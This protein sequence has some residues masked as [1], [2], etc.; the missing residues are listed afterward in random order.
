MYGLQCLSLCNQV[1]NK[2]V[3]NKWNK[4][5]IKMITSCLVDIHQLNLIY[6]C[7]LLIL[8]FSFMVHWLSLVCTNF[9]QMICSGQ[10]RHLSVFF[11]FLRLQIS[12]Y[13]FSTSLHLKKNAINAMQNMLSML[14]Y[15]YMFLFVFFSLL[16]WPLQIICEKFVQ[17]KRI[18][19]HFKKTWGCLTFFFVYI[20]HFSDVTL[21]FEQWIIFK[22]LQFML[23]FLNIW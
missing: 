6:S 2:Q 22:D 15:I 9:S 19:C 10:S 14:F 11:F 8:D 16:D 5:H 12:E 4:I 13:D 3:K 7:H 21:L 1:L 23:L 18:I 17:T 20:I